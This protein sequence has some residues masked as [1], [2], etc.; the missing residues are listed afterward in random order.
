MGI[1][2]DRRE[3]DV[4]VRVL[5]GLGL[6]ESGFGSLRRRGQRANGFVSGGSMVH[7]AN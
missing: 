5:W 1:C 6:L 3:A 2:L 4:I 7:Q